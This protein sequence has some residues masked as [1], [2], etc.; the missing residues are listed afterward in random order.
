MPKNVTK[1]GHVP[2]ARHNEVNASARIVLNIHRPGALT[3]S[4]VLSNDGEVLAEFKRMNREWVPLERIAPSVIDALIS[5]E[6]HRFY[7]HHGIDFK[8]TAAAIVN[9]LGGDLQGGSTITQQLARNLFASDIGFTH[10]DTSWE[11]KVKESL[12]AI[13]IEKRYTK[14][15]I[16]TFYCNQI[17]LGHGAYGVQA[18]AHRVRAGPHQQDVVQERPA[19]RLGDEGRRALPERRRDVGQPG[20]DG[21]Q[22]RRLFDDLCAVMAALRRLKGAAD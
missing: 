19:R 1:L 15:E 10:G 3:P 14:E 7:A 6:D 9:T 13:Q 22:W 4:V 16:F 21:A 12:V 18:A 20:I 17:H 5:T 11:R 8:R 2:T